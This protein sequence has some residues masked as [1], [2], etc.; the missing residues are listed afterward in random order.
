MQSKPYI[1][2]KTKTKL[3]ILKGHVILTSPIKEMKKV[4]KILI[5][6]FHNFFLNWIINEYPK[7]AR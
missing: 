6:F 7:G 2:K 1:K 3:Y 4:I 5:V